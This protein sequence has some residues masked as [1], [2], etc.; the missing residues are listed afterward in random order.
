MRRVKVNFYLPKELMP[1]MERQKVWQ[2]GGKLILEERGKVACAQCWVYQTWCHLRREGVNIGL[3]HEM[4]EEGAVIALTGNIP[5]SFR[6]TARLFI[7][8]IVADGLP[9]PRASLNIVQNAQHARYLPSS[10]F[11]PLWTQPGL[12]E[13]SKDRFAAFE[14]VAFFGDRGNVASELAGET[15]KRQLASETGCVFEIRGAEG[16][17]DYSDVDAVIAV[18]DFRGGRQLHKPATKLYNAWLAGVPFIGGSDSAYAAEGSPGRDYLVAS[19]PEEALS[20]LRELKDNPSL[21]A[22]LVGQGKK[23]GS[24]YTVE[25]VTAR[26]RK[27]V[28]E[29]IPEA[30]E[31]RARR[32][33][34]LNR[35]RDAA[36]RVVCAADRIFRS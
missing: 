3:L 29:T 32:A 12:I 15:W 11:M 35:C 2:D 17:H 16:W 26:W 14:R 20:H 8:G 34:W 25:A 4:P 13:R 24:N 18:R 22:S 9:N 1:S 10:L 5:S 19:S 36:M 30:A 28:E 7:A 31:R 6:T 27:L 23:K 21:R 33:P